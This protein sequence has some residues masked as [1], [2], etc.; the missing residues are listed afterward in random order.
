VAN[1]WADHWVYWLGPLIGA[2]IAA[3]VY[4]FVFLHREE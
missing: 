3:L 2:G 4:E 1:Q